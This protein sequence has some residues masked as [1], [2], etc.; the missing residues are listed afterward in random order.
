MQQAAFPYVNRLITLSKENSR[1][2]LKKYVALTAVYSG[3]LSI[4]ILFGAKII[5]KILLGETYLPSLPIFRIL[6]FFLFLTGLE[7]T[8]SILIMIPMGFKNELAK[9]LWVSSIINIIITTLL[10]K[11]FTYTGAAIAITITESLIVG[12][13]YTCLK[14]KNVL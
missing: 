7:N 11:S 5:T 13:L 14:K 4:I 1:R 9:I 10:V 3:G 2:F 6:S 12:L 8:L